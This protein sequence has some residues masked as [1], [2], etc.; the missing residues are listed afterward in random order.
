MTR[1]ER[2]IGRPAAFTLVL[3][4]AAHVGIAQEHGDCA[5]P[6]PDR[7]IRDCTLLIERG[8]TAADKLAEFHLL[9][10][11]AHF[12][13][14]EADRAL[15][16]FDV[17]IRLAPDQAAPLAARGDAYFQR[18]QFERSVADYEE[19]FRRNPNDAASTSHAIWR[20]RV[21]VGPRRRPRASSN[22]RTLNITSPSI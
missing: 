15:A 4:L 5:H 19:A 16:D 6:V 10:G 11:V 7:S 18:G 12:M 20:C 17:A 22:P 14:E 2:A 13:K 21:W 8:G 3:I 1:K 9:R